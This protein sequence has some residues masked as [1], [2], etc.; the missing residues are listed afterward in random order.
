MT[1]TKMLLRHRV[2][3][4]I[5]I[6]RFLIRKKIRKMQEQVHGVVLDVG[7]GKQPYRNE[8]RHISR[9]LALDRRNAEIIHDLKN[10]PYP[11]SEGSINWVLC[12]QV[13]DDMPDQ[14]AFVRELHRLLDTNGTLILSASFVWELH[15]LP[16]DY[17]RPSPEYLRQLLGRNGFEIVELQHVGNSWIT[18]GQVINTNLRMI[19]SDKRWWFRILSPLLLANSLL[20]Y[21]IGSLFQNPQS[22]RLPLAFFVIARKKQP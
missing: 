22:E 15:D 16:H 10:F 5:H 19:F 6:D 7:S 3:E 17:G 4:L 9:Y 20:F 12:T 8:F 13:L 14:D 1:Q 21:G 2:A 18:L 11:L